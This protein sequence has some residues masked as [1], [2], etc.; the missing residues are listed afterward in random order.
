MRLAA[1]LVDNLE[2]D[3]LLVADKRLVVAFVVGV[4]LAVGLEAEL[5][6]RLQ[7]DLPVAV[8]VVAL[9]IDRLLAVLLRLGDFGRCYRHLP[10]LRQAFLEC[11][12]YF[13]VDPLD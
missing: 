3:T 4:G 5:V 11:L 7:A 9:A 1:A 6:P 2:V 8:V 10:D 12:R 13:L